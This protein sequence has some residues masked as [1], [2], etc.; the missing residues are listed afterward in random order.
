[1]VVSIKCHLGS[2]SH[3]CASQSHKKAATVTLGHMSLFTLMIVSMNR[4]RVS[5]VIVK[6]TVMEK[7]QASYD[8]GMDQ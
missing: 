2:D 6:G 5:L 4:S 8:F 7:T 1:M 3:S